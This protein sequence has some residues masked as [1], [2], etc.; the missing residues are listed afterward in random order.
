MAD[1]QRPILYR[2]KPPQGSKCAGC[3]Q[4]FP[5]WMEAVTRDGVSYYHDAAN[6]GCEE[7]THRRKGATL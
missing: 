2:A 5:E 1:E 7:M 3:G 6:G 4:P